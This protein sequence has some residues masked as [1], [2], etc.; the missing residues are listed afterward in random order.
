MYYSAPVRDAA[1]KVIGVV[2]V[3]LEAETLWRIVE[4]LDLGD[5]GSAM[6]VDEDGI[7]IAHQ[8]HDRLY[9]SL[10]PLSEEGQRRVQPTIPFQSD[11]VPSLDIPALAS[12]HEATSSGSLEYTD[13]KDGTRRT[14]TYAP[15][16]ER[17]WVLA[18]DLDTRAFAGER[19]L[20]ARRSGAGLAVV[21]G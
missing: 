5:G 19:S 1:D 14:V 17:R 6:L 11:T 15:L 10:A 12:L 21:A 18:T 20:L 9:H 4:G 2:V 13:P 8:D 3:K 16:H 7:V